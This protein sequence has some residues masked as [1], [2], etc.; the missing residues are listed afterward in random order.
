[1]YTICDIGS[2]FLSSWQT[3]YSVLYITL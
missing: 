2:S 3:I 1:M